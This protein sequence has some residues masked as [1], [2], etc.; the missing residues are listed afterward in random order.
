MMRVWTDAIEEKFTNLLEAM[1][2]ALGYSF[3]RDLLRTG[4]YHTKGAADHENELTLIR[5]ALVKMTTL[6][7]AV[8]VINVQ[9]GPNNKYVPMRFPGRD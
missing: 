9:P 2:K 5:Q 3:D 8:P 1:A 7:A 6:D 4:G